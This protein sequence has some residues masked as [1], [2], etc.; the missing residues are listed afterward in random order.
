MTYCVSGRIEFKEIINLTSSKPKTNMQQSN[1]S[2]CGRRTL[3]DVRKSELGKT[4][5]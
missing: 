2:R 3:T 4:G 1:K 5:P